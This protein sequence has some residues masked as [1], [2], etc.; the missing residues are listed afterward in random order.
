M[1]QKKVKIEKTG[2]PGKIE[3]NGGQLIIA[4]K[5]LFRDNDVIMQ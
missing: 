1:A 5:L 4:F 2:I 3:K